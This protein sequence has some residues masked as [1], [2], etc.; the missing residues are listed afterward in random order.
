M[1]LLLAIFTNEH[2]NGIFTTDNITVFKG[3]YVTSKRIITWLI[4]LR[5]RKQWKSSDEQ[6]KALEN[7]M[8]MGAKLDLLYND[9]KK[10]KK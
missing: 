3:N 7:A 6:M 10:L 2:P 8:S 1:S 5:T 9:L 4:S